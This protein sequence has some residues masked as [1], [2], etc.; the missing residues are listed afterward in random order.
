[1]ITSAEILDVMEDLGLPFSDA[2]EFIELHRIDEELAGTEG[3]S[4]VTDPG[5][6]DTGVENEGGD[7]L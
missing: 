7:G 5:V 6:T 3:T 1:M 2:V 4:V